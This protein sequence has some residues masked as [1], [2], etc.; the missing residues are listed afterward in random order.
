MKSRELVERGDKAAL[1]DFHILQCGNL[2][3]VYSVCTIITMMGNHFQTIEISDT[4]AEIEEASGAHR[5]ANKQTK[6]T[7]FATVRPRN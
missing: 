4:H 1:S 7:C 3:I 6:S 5:Q 2:C